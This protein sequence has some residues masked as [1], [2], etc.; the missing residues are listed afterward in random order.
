MDIQAEKLLILQQIINTTDV[1]LISDIKALLDRDFD[2]FNE[3]SGE[4]QSDV[5][6]GIAQLDKKQTFTHEEAKKRFGYL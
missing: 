5:S 1:S 4:Q 3:L 6:E 2:W